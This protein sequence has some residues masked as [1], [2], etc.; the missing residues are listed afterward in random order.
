MRISDWSSDVCSSDLRR[1]AGG[2]KGNDAGR[3]IDGEAAIIVAGNDRV[4]DGAADGVDIGSLHGAHHATLGTSF[5]QPE[6]NGVVERRA[7]VI[8]IQHV[9]GV[10]S[11][12]GRPSPVGGPDVECRDGGIVV[13]NPIRI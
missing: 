7:I 1:G 13:I 10:R 8:Y 6:W 11:P 2:G 5:G 9:P 12:G 3:R 4:G